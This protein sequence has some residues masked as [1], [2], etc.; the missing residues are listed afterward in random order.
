MIPRRKK[1]KIADV[2]GKTAAEIETIF[3]DDYGSIGWRI[4]EIKEFKNKWYIVL[5][6]DL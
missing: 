4:I 3:N 1:I 6:M 2:T 5:E